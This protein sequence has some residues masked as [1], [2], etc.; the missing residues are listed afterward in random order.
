MIKSQES[1][2]L[3][4]E[5]EQQ[6]ENAEKKQADDLALL[7]TPT[8]S[9]SGKTCYIATPYSFASGKEWFFSSVDEAWQHYYKTETIDQKRPAVYYDKGY[10]ISIQPLGLAQLIIQQETYLV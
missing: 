9:P 10:F 7:N 4:D 2:S 5:N 1:K 3:A 8:R 6:K